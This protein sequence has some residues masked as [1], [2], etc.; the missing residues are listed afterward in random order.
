MVLGPSLTIKALQKHIKEV[1]HHPEKKLQVV[2]KLI[3]E[4]GELSVEINHE[5]ADGLTDKTKQ[6]IKHELYDVIHFI[7]HIANIYEIDLEEAIIEKDLINEQ[8][9]KRNRRQNND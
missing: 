4:I 8:R 7:N 9:Y 2:L 6:N 1:D 3:E 5:I